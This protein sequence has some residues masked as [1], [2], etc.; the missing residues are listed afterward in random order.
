MRL[1]PPTENLSLTNNRSLLRRGRRAVA[2]EL[3]PT[4]CE[5]PWISPAGN[6]SLVRRGSE[7][8]PV[9]L[10]G[11]HHR[12]ST[13]F[14]RRE[15]RPLAL[16]QSCCNC[17]RRLR[18]MK[19]LRVLPLRG[20][21][22]PPGRW[23]GQALFAALP[24]EEL[25]PPSKCPLCRH[26]SARPAEVLATKTCNK[27]TREGLLCTERPTR[28]QLLF[29]VKVDLRFGTAGIQHRAACMALAAS[30]GL[31]RL[32]KGLKSGR[33]LRCARFFRLAQRR[34]DVQLLCRL[35]CPTSLQR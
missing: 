5:R 20:Q 10:G 12:G 2:V 7:F 14:R 23:T 28:Q 9:R 15:A 33:A 17:E 6:I 13:S 30:P 35:R 31:G 25:S 21:P 26:C 27:V 3:Q 1:S 19:T 8:A 29:R 11:A 32:A 16:Q 22:P 4:R 24:G 18:G 34:S